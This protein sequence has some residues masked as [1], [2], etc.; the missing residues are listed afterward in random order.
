MKNN[1]FSVNSGI[2]SVD[3]QSVNFREI[4]CGNIAPG[5]IYRSSHPVK[6]NKQEKSV[7]ILAA[8]AKIAA[9]V[10]LCDTMSGIFTNA[11][12]AP[13]YNNLLT[14]GKV[15]ALGMNFSCTSPSFKKK[16]KEALQFII[17]T[18]G[19]WLIHCY[20][21]I[22]RTG[23][24]CIVIESFMGASLDE[25][26]NDYLLSFKSGFESSINAPSEKAD[27]NTAM[28]ILSAMSGSQKITEQNLRNIAETYLRSAVALS[29]EETELLRMK[30]SDN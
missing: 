9:V 20:A 25:V 27:I 5:A 29:A 14:S 16:F 3:A 7:S 26:L 12:F 8:H 23:F 24:V 17:R 15:I 30:L 6:N 18:Q 4:R 19:P 11:I 28:Q 2:I 1:F 21:G 13:W 22:D 10:N